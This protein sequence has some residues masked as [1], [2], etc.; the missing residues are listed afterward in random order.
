MHAEHKPKPSAACDV[1]HAPT[2]LHEA[3]NQRCDKVINGRRCY[4]H[5]KSALTDLWDQC[6]TCEGFGRT[7]SQECTACG[8]FGWTVY[9]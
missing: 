3:I 2:N 6:E 4:G 9:T 7:G 5:Y 8:G 1:C